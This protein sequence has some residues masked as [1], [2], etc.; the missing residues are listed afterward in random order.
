MHTGPPSVSAHVLCCSCAVHRRASQG[1]IARKEARISFCAGRLG[2]GTLRTSTWYSGPPFP[3][4]TCGEGSFLEE[5]S[6]PW[7][8]RVFRLFTPRKFQG[9]REDF[10]AS[11]DVDDVAHDELISTPSN[12]KKAVSWG[13]QLVVTVT[14]RTPQEYENAARCC[15]LRERERRCGQTRRRRR[16]RS[17]RQICEA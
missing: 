6:C 7:R 10:P 17:R 9:R 14:H 11:G 5:R 15:P 4:Q 3:A 2:L 13:G 8:V 16:G 1:R 12:N